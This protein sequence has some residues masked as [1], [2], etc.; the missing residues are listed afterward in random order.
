[1][2]IV[3]ADRDFTRAREIA[4]GVEGMGGR[5]FR[6]E[7]LDRVCDIVRK[8]DVGVLILDTSVLEPEGFAGIDL[9]RI[10]G[11][12]LHIVVTTGTPSEEIEREVRSRGVIF[13]APRPVDVYWIREIVHRS[14]TRG[15]L[16]GSGA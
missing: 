12:D 8:R 11:K 14:I 2:D 13:Y 15:S 10:H 5:V 6:A 4:G 16:H 7:D 3:V 1:M 9:V